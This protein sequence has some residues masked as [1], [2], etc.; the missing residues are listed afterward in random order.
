MLKGYNNNKY[1]NKKKK[2]KKNKTKVSKW[3]SVYLHEEERFF[4]TFSQLLFKCEN[5]KIKSKEKV[6][7][8]G[9]LYLVGETKNL[10]NN[11]VS[12]NNFNNNIYV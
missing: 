12:R 9:I 2:K 8:W 5:V 1:S 3:Q 11:K 7:R 4:A 10:L 6:A